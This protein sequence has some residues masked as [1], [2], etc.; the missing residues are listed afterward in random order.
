M[1]KTDEDSYHMPSIDFYEN[2]KKIDINLEATMTKSPKEQVEPKKK[3]VKLDPV[4]M[5][6]PPFSDEYSNF[7]AKAIVDFWKA[8]SKSEGKC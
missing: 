7:E 4:P 8:Q 2:N 1:N 3:R 6:T 5:K